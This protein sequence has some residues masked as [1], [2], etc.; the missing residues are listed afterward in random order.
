MGGLLETIVYPEVSLKGG[1]KGYLRS[2]VWS[3]LEGLQVRG[4]RV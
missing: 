4:F 2:R 1:R 3:R